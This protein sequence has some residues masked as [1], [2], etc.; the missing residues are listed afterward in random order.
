MVVYQTGQPYNAQANDWPK[1]FKNS[2]NSSVLRR[3]NLVK[4]I[5]TPP[6]PVPTTGSFQVQIAVQA[7]NGA[8]VQP[9]G[10]A[11][12]IDGGVHLGS[13]PLVS[14]TCALNVILSSGAHN[15]IAGYPGDPNFVEGFSTVLQISTLNPT[16][17]TV[18]A[19]P[20]SAVMGNSVNLTALVASSSSG[21]ITGSV[22]FSVA[23]GS[24]GTATVSSGKAVLQ[25]ISVLASAGFV[26]G[27][28][29]ITATYAGDN[30]F[31]S[32][33]GRIGINVSLPATAAPTFNQPAG[34]YVGSQSITLSDATANALIHFTI[35]GST[36]TAASSIYSAPITISA[37]TVI[38]AIAIADGYSTSPVAS[39]TI[40]I[41]LAF[42]SPSIQALS[43]AFVKASASAFT[44]SVT[45]GSFTPE[46]V[47]QWNGSTISTNYVSPSQLTA[48]IASSQ[49]AT[50][51]EIAVTVQT[52][53]P[54][55]GT[56]STLEFEID[57]VASSTTPPTFQTP[58][59]T[60]AAGTTA[61]YPVTLSST[62]SNVYVAC[63]NLPARASC[64][65]SQTRNTVSV[66]TSA[67]T[68]S[69]SYQVTVVLTETLP[70]ATNAGLLFPLVPLIAFLRS[71]KKMHWGLVAACVVFC[72]AML[73]SSCGG[74]S[75]SS[76]GGSPSTHQVTT[77][78][79]V[80]LTIQ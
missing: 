67:S 78:G 34:F 33:T 49:V 11:N 14:G 31:A 28:N 2:R 41:V 48:Q 50:P 38:Q 76:G 80:A 22:S 30:T 75:S 1:I 57:S 53:S 77:S 6:N 9:T 20:V 72:L 70:G 66:S 45:G 73:T 21:Q 54:G 59:A 58:S 37:T 64:S 17:T 65:Y 35:D 24:L 3:A 13:C 60:V 62:A 32:S 40:T 5:L 7:G 63:L 42:P 46:S 23:G 16:T 39:A 25:N 71:R 36:P 61:T 79:V 55:G 27:K 69:G 18:S 74:G 44:L 68:P 52:P 8:G 15:L 56:S 10:I 12:L 47:I 51:G 43:P 26:G 19:A 29:T 4:V